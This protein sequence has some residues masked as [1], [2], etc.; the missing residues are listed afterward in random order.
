MIALGLADT[1][2]PIDPSQQ[3]PSDIDLPKTGDE[4]D[5]LLWLS[6]AMTSMAA[7]ALVSRKKREV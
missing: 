7:L 5:I 6:L 4:S 1:Y 3:V 2:E